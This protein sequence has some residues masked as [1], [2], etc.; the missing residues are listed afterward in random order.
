MLVWRSEPPASRR[1]RPWTL[2]AF[3]PLATKTKS[4]SDLLHRAPVISLTCHSHER[5]LCCAAASSAILARRVVVS[6]RCGRWLHA[7]IVAWRALSSGCIVAR[8]L[9]TLMKCCRFACAGFFCS[10]A[11]YVRLLAVLSRVRAWAQLVLVRSGDALPL[12]C[13]RWLHH[14]L[15]CCA[16]EVLVGSTSCNFAQAGRI[17]LVHGCAAAHH[18]HSAG[19]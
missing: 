11:A 1:L 19:W 14:R 6:G 15:R 12:L 3:V 13:C 2:C 8:R 7:V 5:L 10:T 17:S 9:C 18:P 4:G 16:E